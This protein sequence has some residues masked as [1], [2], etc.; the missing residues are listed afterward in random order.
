MVLV[1]PEEIVEL[2]KDKQNYQGGVAGHL[3]GKAAGTF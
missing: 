1:A 2:E 3:W